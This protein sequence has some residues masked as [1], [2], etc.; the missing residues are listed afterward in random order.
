MFDTPVEARQVIEERFAPHDVEM[1]LGQLR[2]AITFAKQDTNTKGGTR[3]GGTPDLSSVTPWPKR[4]VPENIEELSKR[5]G[6][7]YDKELRDH[8][9]AGMSYAFFAQVDLKEAADLGTAAASL[10]NEGRLLFFYDMIAGPFDTG[11][12]SGRVIWDRSPSAELSPSPLPDDLAKAAAAYRKMIDETNKQYGLERNAREEGAP[13][14]G[15]PYAGPS[16]PV[17]L[18][19]ALQLPTFSSLEFEATGRLAETYA[20]DRAGAGRTTEF[21]QAYDE[22][23]DTYYSHTHLLGLPLPVQDDPRYDAVVVTEFK[24]QHLS[25]EAWSKNKAAVFA[26]AAE[27]RVLLQID[28]ADWMQDNAEGAVYFLIRKDDLEKR[29]F[30]RVVTVYQQ[31]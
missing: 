16:R 6:A 21:S 3:I 25:G 19:S 28:V 14:P 1:L 4:P 29:A 2:P 18:K 27:W 8:L 5:S 12:Q 17:A 9:A 7:P 20:A 11:M 24:T 13:E 31:T 23:A 26:K 15:S 22:L 30:D 10:P